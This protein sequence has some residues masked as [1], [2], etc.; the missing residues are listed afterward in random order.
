MPLSFNNRPRF[1][2]DLVTQCQNVHL[3]PLTLCRHVTPK[4]DQVTTLYTSCT[5]PSG[6]VAKNSSAHARIRLHMPMV[7]NSEKF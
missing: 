4:D 2:S 5:T 6:S 7:P 3:P 1:V